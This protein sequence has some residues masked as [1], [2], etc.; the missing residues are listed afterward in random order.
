MDKVA[1]RTEIRARMGALTEAEREKSDEALFAR[2]LALPEVERA[3]T[4]ML[5]CG[6]GAEPDTAR[7]ISKLIAMGK[8]VALPK[9]LPGWKMEARRV[10]TT[11]ELVR[12]SYG[13]LEPGEDCPVVSREE[14]DLILTPGL[15]FDKNCY[16]LGQGG[17]YYDR[18][19]AH[20][21]GVAVALCRGAFL[22]DAVPTQMHDRPVDMVL[23][24]TASIFGGRV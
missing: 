6:M 14:I 18:Y 13:M 3:G 22:L 10:A 21:T 20:Y 17:G 4:I 5:Y 2:F 1:A 23:T 16:R 8:S 19:L 11:T 7:L 15:A 12:H 9:C 24:E